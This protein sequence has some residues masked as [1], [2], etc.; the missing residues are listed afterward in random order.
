MLGAWLPGRYEGAVCQPMSC[1]VTAVPSSSPV[2][3][4]GLPH[5][6]SSV[7]SGAPHVVS[8]GTAAV[9]SVRATAPPTAAAVRVRAATAWR[10]R[11]V[12]RGLR[13]F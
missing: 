10:R 2:S 8:A 5:V 12:G 11:E 4:G 7:V 1:G 6:V 3:A 13:C 9:S